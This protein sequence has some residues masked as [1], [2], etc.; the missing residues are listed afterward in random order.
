M[1]QFSLI[2]VQSGSE[3][4]LTPPVKKHLQCF[5][6]AQVTKQNKWNIAAWQ[7]CKY[8]VLLSQN[9]WMNHN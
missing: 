5:H 2:L 6:V 3:V 4:T 1:L 9:V 7:N 8:D